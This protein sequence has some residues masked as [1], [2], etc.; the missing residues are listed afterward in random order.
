MSCPYEPLLRSYGP[1]NVKWCEE[2]LCSLVQEPA[3]TWSNLPFILIGLWILW[4]ARGRRPF[5]LLG[6][7][8]VVMGALSLVYHAS[9]TYATQ[10]LDFV[11]MFVYL[12]LLLVWNLRRLGV[13][14]R[15]TRSVAA[16]FLIVY[17]NMALLFVFPLVLGLPIQMIIMF[18]TAVVFALE[19]LL[20]G[21]G[22]PGHAGR[23][24][25]AVR[26]YAVAVLLLAGAAVAS[27][28]DLTRRWCD[29]TNHW[30]QG[31]A[32][33]HIL[34]AGSVVFVFRFYEQVGTDPETG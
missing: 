19:A 24:H 16:Y 29:P 7:A 15:T 11:G 28:L 10:V 25:G 22:G 26:E 4:Q 9:N 8:A 12:S 3:N 32:L 34:A 5:Q 30:V 31:H 33:W 2:R 23:S 20:A 21:R 14:V 1:P 6:T 17:A 27:S 13:L 18:D